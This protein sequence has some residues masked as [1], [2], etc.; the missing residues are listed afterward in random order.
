MPRLI[1]HSLLTSR[2]LRI[3]G[4]SLLR[5]DGSIAFSLL[6]MLRN[7]AEGARSESLTVDQ[8]QILIGVVT[9]VSSLAVGLVPAF[10]Y[11][12]LLFRLIELA[13]VT[14]GRR[15]LSRIEGTIVAFRSQYRSASVR[16]ILYALRTRLAGVRIIQDLDLVLQVVQ[17]PLNLLYPCI[18]DSSRK[19]IYILSVQLCTYY[20]HLL[21]LVRYFNVV[22]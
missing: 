20:Q 19:P 7:Q 2:I 8:N 9:T 22:T 17:Y 11:A 4:Y 14:V 13:E 15:V 3:S 10:T 21:C 12:T 5:L 6:S 16:P 18:L 1:Q